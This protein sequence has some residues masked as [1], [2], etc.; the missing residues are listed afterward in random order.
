MV[1]ILLPGIPHRFRKVD[2]THGSL[3]LM[4][5]DSEWQTVLGDAFFDETSY[6]I[7]ETMDGGYIATGSITSLN[8]SSS[9]LW[10]RKLTLRTEQVVPYFSRRSKRL[11]IFY[12][13]N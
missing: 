2:M 10:V 8:T 6:S 12:P 4:I 7:Q 3:K 1:G 11:W 5:P 13:S 9:D